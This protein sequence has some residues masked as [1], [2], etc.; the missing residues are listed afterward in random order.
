MT[1]LNKE[2]ICN[3][4]KCKRV[5]MGNKIHSKHLNEKT[6]KKSDKNTTFR[7]PNQVQLL[8][9]ALIILGGII[10]FL[11]NN[12]YGEDPLKNNPI[13]KITYTRPLA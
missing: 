9:A 4:G 1:L 11:T 5:R 7:S 6:I 13:L 3:D 10:T 2:E 12:P 8:F